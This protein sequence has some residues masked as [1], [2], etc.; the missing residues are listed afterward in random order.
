MRGRRGLYFS[1][2]RKRIVYL[3]ASVNISEIH[4]HHA[5]LF[6]GFLEACFHLPLDVGVIS[7]ADEDDRSSLGE[8]E[9]KRVRVKTPLS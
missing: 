1:F 7:E 6:T 2:S 8:G 3:I 9:L 4:L 5:R